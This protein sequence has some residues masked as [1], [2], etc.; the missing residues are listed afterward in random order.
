MQTGGDKSRKSESLQAV[1]QTGTVGFYPLNS[2]AFSA[3]HHRQAQCLIGMR[4]DEASQRLRGQSEYTIGKTTLNI[5]GCV[6]TGFSD[7]FYR[8]K[9]PE[10]VVISSGMMEIPAFIEEFMDFLE[11]LTSLGFI[12]ASGDGEDVA[13]LDR[14]VPQLVIASYGVMYDVIQE[15][16]NTAMVNMSGFSVRQRERLLQKLSRGMFTVPGDGYDL[17]LNENV[18]FPKPLALQLAGSK[19]MYT[20]RTNQ[21][22]ESHRITTD[23]N[24]NGELGVLELELNLAY[25]H[26]IYRL[27][28]ACREQGQTCDVGE[29]E[30]KEVMD[31]L[32][33]NL[34]ILPGLVVVA[35]KAP[36]VKPR[37]LAVTTMDLA[38]L[39]QLAVMAKNVN[40]V[41][42]QVMFSSLITQIKPMVEKAQSAMLSES[43]R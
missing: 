10:L 29:P 37:D 43:T 39:H 13:V 38:I 31:Q 3:L 36:G 16:F 35:G 40:H 28:P 23:F 42:A 34:G 15:K 6:F 12:N 8:G 21:L 41:A 11:K 33:Q 18:L 26:L 1:V 25:R 20:V 7:A 27:L 30:I 22:L 9:L 2:I 24:P 4:E 19:S 5:Q 14:Y 32:G 17:R